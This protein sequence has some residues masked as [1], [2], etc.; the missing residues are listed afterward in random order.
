MDPSEPPANSTLAKDNTEPASEGCCAA[1]I[2]AIGILIIFCAMVGLC[3]IWRF[4][5]N[6]RE[7]K[8]KELAELGAWSI[9]DE[10]TTGFVTN[11]HA[12]TYGR[13]G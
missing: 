7:S 6:R 11:E 4:I 9:D 5:V 3:I 13:G 12:E 2:T 1:W 8:Y 10:D